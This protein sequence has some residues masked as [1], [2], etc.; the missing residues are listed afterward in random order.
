MSLFNGISYFSCIFSG[1]VLIWQDV[2][3][4]REIVEV[5]FLEK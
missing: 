5:G 1:C 2:Y 3:E 4:E